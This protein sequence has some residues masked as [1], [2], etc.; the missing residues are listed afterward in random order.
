LIAAETEL[1][2]LRQMYADGDVRVRATGARVAELRAELEKNLTGP[3]SGAAVSGLASSA[4]STSGQSPFPSLREL[5]ALGVS[6]AD[7]Y[8]NTKIQEAVFQ[9]LTQEFELAKVQEVKE[10][11]S[12]KILD[13]PDVPEKKVFPPRL[14]IILLGAMLSLAT[15]LAWLFSRQAWVEAEPDDPQIALAAEVFHTVC[16]RLPWA[17]SNG[18]DPSVGA[19]KAVRPYSGIKEDPRGR[20]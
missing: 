11:P 14:V 12:V 19:G 16:A 5:P 1:Q 4:H 17:S 20:R 13:P 9:T 7:L 18:S 15:G 2:G 3:A 10:T 8:R 6:Y